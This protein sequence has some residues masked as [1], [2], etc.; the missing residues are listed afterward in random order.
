MK[1]IEIDLTAVISKDGK[2]RQFLSWTCAHEK[3]AKF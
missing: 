2:T 3:E 1:P